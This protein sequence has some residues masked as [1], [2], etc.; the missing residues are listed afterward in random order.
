[1]MIIVTFDAFCKKDSISMCLNSWFMEQFAL[2][3]SLMLVNY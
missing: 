1:V 2:V 3:Y